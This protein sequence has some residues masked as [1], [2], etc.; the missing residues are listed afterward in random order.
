MDLTIDAQVTDSPSAFSTNTFYL[1]CCRVES[2][3]AD[4]KTFSTLVVQC[5]S[6]SNSQFMDV[7]SSD[8][9]ILC[10]LLLCCHSNTRGFVVFAT[11]TDFICK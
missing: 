11:V 4:L 9:S 3:E 1:V 6:S 7:R 5:S 10:A 2:C 8:T